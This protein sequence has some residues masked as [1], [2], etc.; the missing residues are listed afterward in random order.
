MHH[1]C[2]PVSIVNLV[3][4]IRNLAKQKSIFTL[5]AQNGNYKVF[6]YHLKPMTVHFRNCKYHTVFEF[7]IHSNTNKC[8]NCLVMYISP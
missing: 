3:W 4:F 8:I 7:L 2:F 5:Y 6:C 1:T